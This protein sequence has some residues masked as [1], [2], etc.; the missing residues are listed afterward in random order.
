M[1]SKKLIGERNYNKYTYNFMS[2]LFEYEE[3]ILNLN[4]VY[5]RDDIWDHEDKEKLLDSVF[6]DVPIGVITRS[7]T[8]NQ[9]K[10][11]S[12]LNIIDGKQRLRTLIDYVHDK[13]SYKGFKFSEL[14]DEDQRHINNL[15][16]PLIEI[17]NPTLQE[18]I[19]VFIKL[20]IHGKLMSNEY[21]ER[22]KELLK[23]EEHE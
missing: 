23:D 21:I 17:N 5:Q 19:Q 8:I 14:D 7:K 16:L 11:D 13:W 12:S 6:A 9:K 20:N 2:F 4:P 15:S 10:E 22:A 1:F 3:G 18:E